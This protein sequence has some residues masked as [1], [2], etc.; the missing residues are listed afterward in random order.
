MEEFGRLQTRE[1]WIMEQEVSWPKR[2]EQ[3]SRFNPSTVQ[4]GYGQWSSRQ[5]VQQT[6]AKRKHGLLKKKK[7]GEGEGE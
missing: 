1:Y 6:W 4:G 5:T 2:L 7:M 3:R